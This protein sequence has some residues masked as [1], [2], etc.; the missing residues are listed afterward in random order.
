MQ[1]VTNTALPTITGVTWSGQTL[2]EHNGTWNPAATSY[3]YQWE[4]CTSACV[5]IS[6]ATAEAYT[7][8]APTS[9]TIEVA[10]TADP[11]SGT[12]A[13]TSAATAAVTAPPSVF[14]PTIS[15][16]AQQGRR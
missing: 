13:A 11:G 5:A 9:A 14:N 4:R 16:I 2:T 15:G 1:P 8:T 10:E 12:T 3:A 6:G 7:L